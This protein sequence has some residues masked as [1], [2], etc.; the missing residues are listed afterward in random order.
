ML[1]S[2]ASHRYASI[3]SQCL[4]PYRLDASLQGGK[5][6]GESACAEN[7]LIG[8]HQALLACFLGYSYV[9]INHQHDIVQRSIVMVQHSVDCS[10]LFSSSHGTDIL[11]LSVLFF[12]PQLLI[13]LTDSMYIPC[14]SIRVTQIVQN[15]LMFS[16]GIHRFHNF[17]TV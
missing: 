12:R 14:V 17:K 11:Q 13:F 16:L 6:K 9:P 2:P 8:K 5:C 1:Q 4:I 15:L 7:I 3:Q 10:I